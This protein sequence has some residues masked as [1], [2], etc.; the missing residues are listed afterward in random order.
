MNVLHTVMGNYPRIGDCVHMHQF[1]MSGFAAGLPDDCRILWRCDGE[2]LIIQSPEVHKPNL[3]PSVPVP[4]ETLYPPAAELAFVLHAAP[5]VKRDGKKFPIRDTGEQGA[6]LLSQLNPE[7]AGCRVLEAHGECLPDL[8]G[9]H[10]GHAVAY[11]RTAFTGR[12]VVTD[13]ERFAA[14]L[15]AGVGNGKAWGLGLLTVE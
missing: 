13:T 6:W 4:V 7:R 1:V 14:K 3:Y 10:N 9:D 11:I 12:L 8:R 2:C 15:V 5:Q